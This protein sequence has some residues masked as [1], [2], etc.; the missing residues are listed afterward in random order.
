[1]D[2]QPKKSNGRVY[3]IE[4]ADN[5]LNGFLSLFAKLPNGMQAKILEE[6]ANLKRKVGINPEILLIEVKALAAMY[7]AMARGK[8][9][10]ELK[11]SPSFTVRLSEIESAAHALQGV[12][13]R[14]VKDNEPRKK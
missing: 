5:Q 7:G 13:D 8:D 14:L 2:N 11:S 10:L 12:S 1:M 4:R 3:E 9:G 6:I